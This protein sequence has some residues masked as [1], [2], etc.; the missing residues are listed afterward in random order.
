[1]ADNSFNKYSNYN[2]NSSFSSIVFG[3]EKPV[4]EVELNELQQ[5]I[6][7]FRKLIVSMFGSGVFITDESDKS[8]HGEIVGETFSINDLLVTGDSGVIFK[9]NSSKVSFSGTTFSDSVPY[10]VY[11]KVWEEIVTYK[12]T[13]KKDGEVNSENNVENTIMDSRSPVETTRRKVLKKELLFGETVPNNTDKETYILIATL[14]EVGGVKDFE[15]NIGAMASISK[16]M[17]ESLEQITE[18]LDAI[19]AKIDQGVTS[20][21]IELSF[22]EYC[23]LSDEEKNN[24]YVYLVPDAVVV[25]DDNLEL[26]VDTDGN[27][28]VR[29]DDGIAE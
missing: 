17:S 13:L 18:R 23:A 10:Y 5:I 25:G 22:E 12:D 7:N 19:Q 21:F 15:F 4:L 9:V 2:E 29:Y 1:M 8:E 16:G 27:L 11:Y 14:K 24:G 20:G 28:V 26:D 6:G 3:A